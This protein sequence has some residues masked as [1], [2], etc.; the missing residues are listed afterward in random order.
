MTTEAPAYSARNTVQSIQIGLIRPSPLN[1]RKS[2]DDAALAELT[3]SIRQHGVLQPILVR[4]AHD[5]FEVV[6]GERRYRAAAAAGLAS[7]PATI[8]E[9]T[10]REHLELAIVE[11]LQRRDLSP[12]EAAAGYQALVDAGMRQTEIA[13]A[14]NREQP[15]IAKALGLLKLPPDVQTLIDDGQLTASHGYALSKWAKFP[16]VTS[17]LAGAVASSK[18]TSKDLENLGLQLLPYQSDVVRRVRDWGVTAEIAETCKHCPFGAYRKSEYGDGICL[19]PEHYDELAA[20]VAQQ[21]QATVRAKLEEAGVSGEMPSLEDLKY[22]TYE[23]IYDSSPPPCAAG[24]CPCLTRA[25]R[26]FGEPTVICTDVARLQGLKRQATLA[27]N[28]DRRAKATVLQAKADEKIDQLA[29][30]GPREM[31][32]L[33]RAALERVPASVK[34]PFLKEQAGIQGSYV[35]GWW[36]PL[37]GVPAIMQLKLA[38]AVLVAHEVKEIKEYDR[39]DGTVAWWLEEQAVKS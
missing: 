26:S 30:F 25:A 37:A 1:P 28:K 10:D 16:A 3:E 22:G 5:H 7:I 17:E 6:A 24:E 23:H 14:V 21:R 4:P 32:L 39:E 35:A 31:T 9:L 38:L 13:A 33:L 27:K 34:D 20:A 11:N 18:R 29:G 8:R 36:Q 2:F 12:L 15:A 19:K